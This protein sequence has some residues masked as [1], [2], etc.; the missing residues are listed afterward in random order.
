MHFRLGR[1]QDFSPCVA[2]L[3]SNQCFKAS[4]TFYEELESLWQ[5]M[6][7]KKLFSGF[8]VW[9]DPELSESEKIVSFAMSVVISDSFAQQ[10]KDTR[11]PWLAHRF[12]ESLISKNKF[13]TLLLDHQ[14]IARANAGDGINLVVLHNPLRFHKLA[15]PRNQLLL[16]LG[17]KA[18]YFSH[19]GFY[20]KAVYWEV[21][22]S[23]YA[24]FLA[25]GGYRE[26]HNY[27]DHPDVVGIAPDRIPY[28]YQLARDDNRAQSY[29]T[30]NL[31]L[32]TRRRP[33]MRFTPKQQQLLFYALAGQSDR[34][35]QNALSIS[36]DA[37]KQVWKQIMYRAA[38]ALPIQF[39]QE[40][41]DGGCRGQS[42]RHLLLAYLRQHMEELRPY[43]F[44]TAS[45]SA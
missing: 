27:S 41:S 32:F 17:P 13:D 2:L 36:E 12:Y 21:Y 16:P 1:E 8:V 42:R 40:S 9:E 11:I 6:L 10:L 35:L 29:L 30:N 23:E 25:N 7:A 33:Q 19:D 18:F 3:K 14:Q 5:R 24:D 44:D 15:D 26:L 22:G 37:I 45:A 38:A 39:T 43:H 31:W 20:T 34:E 4:D 28:L